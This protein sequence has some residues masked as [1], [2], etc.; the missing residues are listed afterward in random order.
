MDLFGDLPE[1]A[2]TT[3]EKEEEREPVLFDDLPPVSSTDLGAGG[4]LLFDD[5]PPASSGNLASHSTEYVCP[6]VSHGKGVKRSS[7]E[8]KKNGSEERV[9]KKVLQVFLV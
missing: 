1:P 9:E 2:T 5:L 3:T 6:P 8:E 7:T 4:S